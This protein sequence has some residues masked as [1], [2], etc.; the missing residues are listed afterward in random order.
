MK[1]V[2]MRELHAAATSEASRSAV[3]TWREAHHRFRLLAMM[4]HG[5]SSALPEAWHSYGTID[6][7]RSGAREM[8][9][10]QRVRQVAIIEDRPPLQFVEWVGR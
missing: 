4:V 7:A 6:A 10:D 8:L 2:A 1:N 3:A 5:K 9:N